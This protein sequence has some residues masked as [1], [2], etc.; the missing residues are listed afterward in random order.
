MWYIYE[1]IVYIG[2]ILYVHVTFLSFQK[3]VFHIS[4]TIFLAV[5]Q[6]CILYNIGFSNKSLPVH[7]FPDSCAPSFWESPARREAL[8]EEAF[9]FLSSLCPC[10]KGILSCT[11]RLGMSAALRTEVLTLT[12]HRIWCGLTRLVVMRGTL[13][14]HSKA[15]MER[16][17]GRASDW[18]HAAKT[19][20]IS[21]PTLQTVVF[22]RSNSCS[23]QRPAAQQWH[24]IDTLHTVMWVCLRLWDKRELQTKTCYSPENKQKEC[25]PVFLPPFPL[26]FL[27]TAKSTPFP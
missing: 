15:M 8:G 19:W 11:W 12:G 25:H 3:Y 24:H 10:L 6:L 14:A 23:P 26:F 20:T 1:Y 13:D 27:S 2:N 4:S 21:A 5:I 22:S 9:L 16:P 18:T 17:V 7:I